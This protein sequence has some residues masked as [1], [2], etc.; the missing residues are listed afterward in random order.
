MKKKQI[1]SI[2]LISLATSTFVGCGISQDD[3][4]K[5]LE[6]D[7]YKQA[8]E[9][10][11]KL[12]DEDKKAMEAK[13]KEEAEIIKQKYI[14]EEVDSITAIAGLT[15][16]KL[17]NGMEEIAN[18]AMTIINKIEA[19]RTSYYNAEKKFAAGEWEK[20]LDEYSKVI[21][22]DVKNYDVAKAKIA[23]TTKKIEDSILVVA[24]SAQVKVQHDEYK[25][26]YPDMMGTNIIN[27][28]DQAIKNIE[29]G[30]LAWDANKFPLKVKGQYSFGSEGFE[31]IGLGENI[32]VVPGG[33]WGDDHGWNL[34]ENHGI[35][36]LKANVKKVEFY[37]GTTWTNP[38]YKSWLEQYKEKPLQ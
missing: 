30:F 10:Y 28:S 36:T 15:E 25:S 19:S 17:V 24:E 38:L 35:A 2:L 20:A 29:I 8:V 13:F 9:S 1:L 11:N 37:D 23:E 27:K 16:I 34:N 14:K 22:D 18:N 31:F 12:K 7:N 6:Q 21:S 5:A 33:T 26:L 3:V 32:N 4:N